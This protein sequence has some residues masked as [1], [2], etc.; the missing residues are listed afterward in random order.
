MSLSRVQRLYRRFA[1]TLGH[2]LL[3]RLAWAFRGLP[4]AKGDRL[5][6]VA[7]GWRAG[8]FVEPWPRMYGVTDEEERRDQE[9]IRDYEEECAAE[10]AAE[11]D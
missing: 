7:E 6:S 9:A 5:G 2:Q 8:A 3:S 10:L 11:E 4:R 1:Q